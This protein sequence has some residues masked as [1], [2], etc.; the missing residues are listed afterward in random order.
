MIHFKYFFNHILLL[1][2][3]ILS[4][5]G[6]GTDDNGN[7]SGS[8]LTVNVYEQYNVP[9][10][11]AV[12]QLNN[13]TVGSQTTRESGE[14]VFSI[15]EGSINDI[16]VFPPEGYDWYSVYGSTETQLSHYV[17]SQSVGNIPQPS[18]FSYIKI[19]GTI[20]NYDPANTYSYY[21]ELDNGALYSEFPMAITNNSYEIN[22]RTNMAVGTS[23]SGKLSILE[24]STDVVTGQT[25]LTDAVIMNTRNYVTVEQN[26][27]VTTQDVSMSNPKPL[28][29]TMLTVNSLQLPSG[30]IFSDSY[31]HERRSSQLN[32]P[33]YVYGSSTTDS[34]PVITYSSYLPQQGDEVGYFIDARIPNEG[35]YWSYR[36]RFNTAETV[37]IFPWFVEPLNFLE[38]QTGRTISWEFPAI[39]NQSPVSLDFRQFINIVPSSPTSDF[40]VWSIEIFG[41]RNS[42]SLPD[43]PAGVIPLLTVGAEYSVSN[44]INAFH[45]RTPGNIEDQY[46]SEYVY[47]FTIW[48]R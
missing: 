16:H 17:Y 27:I 31:V 34:N 46:R 38:G 20:S 42:I 33:Q 37:D 11:G 10:S 21:L 28:L 7:S 30:M 9:F 48:T 2:V 5:C 43:L 23:V 3:L 26:G 35:K 44:F 24:T 6:G 12:V 1:F 29:E 45:V 15:P 36:N 4:G 13:D 25:M 8:T 14:V 40:F 39:N 41:G 18:L 47:D 22:L 32:F 19:S